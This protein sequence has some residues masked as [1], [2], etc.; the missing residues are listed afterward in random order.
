MGVG[1]CPHTLAR[2]CKKHCDLLPSSPTSFWSRHP[3]GV[4]RSWALPGLFPTKSRSTQSW[5]HFCAPPFR[6]D[7]HASGSMGRT[8]SPP[9]V[10]LA[11]FCFPAGLL[12]PP[13]SGQ[14]LASGFL[15]TISSKTHRA[16]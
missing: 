14:S 9:L 10:W 1:H 7:A 8:F 3:L 2:S 16:G 4:N 13:I 11:S 12:S 6:A 15:H 5:L